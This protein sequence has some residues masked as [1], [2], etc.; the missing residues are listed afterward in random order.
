MVAARLSDVMPDDS[1]TRVTYGLLNLTHRHGSAE[2]AP[3]QPGR[4]Y[5]VTVKLNDIAQRFPAGHRLRVS[6]S[7]SYWPLAWPPPEPV[8]LRVE[9]GHSRLV[10]PE[11]P[12][13]SED[14]VIGF[15]PAEG[16]PSSP[17]ERRGTPH[18]N[19]RVIR[20]LANDASTLEVINDDARQYLPALDL[21]LQR[22]AQEWYSSRGNDFNS[23][24]GETF[25]RRGLKR[26]AWSIRTETRT[27]LTSTPGHFRLYA[28]LDAYEGEH[29]VFAETWNE[30]IERDGV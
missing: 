10:L 16:A 8:R 13:R 2:P 18:H 12:T 3:L 9:T 28:Q 14:A 6:L 11:R 4:I 24:R 5:R 29:R 21:E 22:S 25:W 7:T 30:T 17:V 20:D 27:V 1:A 15:A 26:R 19:W 23:V